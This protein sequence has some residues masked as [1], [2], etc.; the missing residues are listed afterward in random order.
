MAIL[1]F[2][3]SSDLK[4]LTPIATL[5]DERVVSLNALLPI[6]TFSLPAA[7]DLNALLPMAEFLEP[8]EEEQE[9][10]RT[11]GII[12]IPCGIRIKRI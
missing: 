9:G 6:A 1:L 5:L 8:V 4:A 10:V 11:N 2:P 12:V 3:L 7:K